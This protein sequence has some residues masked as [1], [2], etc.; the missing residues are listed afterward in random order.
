MKRGFTLLELVIVIIIIGVLATLGIQQYGR[1]VER[2]RGAE[3]RM[4]L[5]QIRTS[6]AAHRLEYGSL[7]VPA[8]DPFTPTRAGIGTDADQI[9]QDCSRNTHYFMYTVSADTAEHFIATATRCTGDTG[10][11]PT[12]LSDFTLTLDTDFGAG[13]DVWGGT[14]G[15]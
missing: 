11:A 3:A 4:I 14:G 12:G 1:M 13:T 10:K 6:A 2:A 15:Y 9:P 8:A 7:L 5:G